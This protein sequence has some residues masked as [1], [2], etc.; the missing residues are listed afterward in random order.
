VNQLVNQRLELQ[1]EVSR[2]LFRPI[3][4]DLAT[5]K[6]TP[7]VVPKTNV[8]SPVWPVRISNLHGE[9]EAAAVVWLLTNT[10]QIRLVDVILICAYEEVDTTCTVDVALRHYEDALWVWCLLYGAEVDEHYLEVYPLRA[11]RGKAQVLDVSKWTPLNADLRITR[12]SLLQDCSEAHPEPQG[13]FE[14]QVALFA[15]M[16]MN[17]GGT[18]GDIKE[19][20]EGTSITLMHSK[21][22]LTVL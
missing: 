1:H 13:D 15:T 18:E 16:A 6:V 5:N 22:I 9:T 3:K 8:S 11:M 20:L 21:Q 7:W 4:D 17:H 19:Q 14:H 2:R 10:C 12:W